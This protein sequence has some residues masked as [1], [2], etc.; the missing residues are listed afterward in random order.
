MGIPGVVRAQATVLADQVAA[1]HDGAAPALAAMLADPTPTTRMAALLAVRRLGVGV[2]VH[3]GLLDGVTSALFADET[4]LRCEAAVAL[5]NL[6]RRLAAAPEAIDAIAVAARD[7]RDGV[8]LAALQALAG[9]R[10]AM[11]WRSAAVEA[12]TDCLGDPVPELRPVAAEVLKAAGPR[13]ANHAAAISAA[14][15]MLDAPDPETRIVAC[16]AL[17]GLGPALVG[18]DRAAAAL[19]AIVED[20]GGD[21]EVRKEAASTLTT[22]ASMLGSVSGVPHLMLELLADRETEV[23]QMASSTLAGMGA[24]LGDRPDVIAALDRAAREGG[25]SAKGAME[26]LAGMG[27]ALA[28]QPR[29]VETLAGYL[30]RP[31]DPLALDAIYA[32]AAIG[33]RLPGMPDLAIRIVDTRIGVRYWYSRVKPGC[34]RRLRE[35]LRECIDELEPLVVDAFDAGS[36]TQARS[37]V[38]VRDWE[39]RLA[40]RPALLVEVAGRLVADDPAARELAADLLYRGGDGFCATPAAVASVMAALRHGD[41]VVRRAA[42]RVVLAAGNGLEGQPGLADAA[43]DALADPGV[44][45][46]SLNCERRLGVPAM[47][48][49]LTRRA[50]DP[51]DRVARAVMARPRRIS[52][53]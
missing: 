28:D 1:G 41:P 29:V 2:V 3:A 44:P 39:P 4:E 43:V 52:L 31:E 22:A 19:L 25:P 21:V 9:L 20:P 16:R 49:I 36:I 38:L 53:L 35:Q 37:A 30:D 45:L 6:G 32:L 15:D 17:A 11:A 46:P 10:H 40:L 33:R 51:D 14:C 24:G 48:E 23:G 8:R 42:L 47:K 34:L 50:A 7:P 26:A 5:A 18:I 13:L 12:V 27:E